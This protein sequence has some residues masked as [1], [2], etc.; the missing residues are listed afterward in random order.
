MHRSLLGPSPP[1]PARTE[2]AAAR[3]EPME[4]QV[5]P[6]LAPTPALAGNAGRVVVTVGEIKELRNELLAKGGL[7]WT[8]NNA[9][10]KYIRDTNER[11]PGNPVVVEVDLTTQEELRIGVL[12]RTKGMAYTFV[13]NEDQVWKWRVM[14]ATLADDELEQAVGFGVAKITRAP[15]QGSY[16]HARHHAARLGEGP[17]FTGQ[18]P[19]WD[20]LVTQADG[21][22]VRFHPQQTKRRIKVASTKA[23]P[24]SEPPRRGLGQSDGRGTYQRYARASHP[25][26]T[27]DGGV[28]D[29]SG[30]STAPPPRPAITPGSEAASSQGPWQAVGRSQ[31]QPAQQQAAPQVPEPQPRPRWREI[32]AQ[33]WWC[34]GHDGWWYLGA[35]GLWIQWSRSRVAHR[36]RGVKSTASEFG[37]PE[38]W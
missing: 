5:P 21:T 16:D 9:A 31:Q 24:P 29:A 4:D 7:P 38:R 15:L 10:L 2:P 11:P 17:K 37:K 12:H 25:G 32:D 1:P 26:I 28:A 18:A 13:E 35:C 27:R 20:F 3:A 23:P 33:E 36:D 6:G 19:I 30:V 8:L 22:V 34:D 14:L